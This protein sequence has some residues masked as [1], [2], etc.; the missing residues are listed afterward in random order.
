MD[1]NVQRVELQISKSGSS[2]QEESDYQKHNRDPKMWTKSRR[3]DI[4]LEELFE[5]AYKVATKNSYSY[6][7]N[8]TA[9]TRYITF[10]GNCV[11]VSGQAGSGKTTL[12]KQLVEKILEE[13]H[14]KVDFLFYVSLKNV[15]F[16]E[17]IGVLQ[18]LLTNLHSSWEH[19]VAT[20]K[21]LLQ[22][23]VETNKV[24]III[25]G[26]DEANMNL[27]GSCPTASIYDVTTPETILKNLLDG[28]IMPNAKKLITSRPRQLLE[29][30]E[31]YRPD[32][33]VNILGLNLD[34]QK[35][36]CRDICGSNSDR[37]YEYLVKHPELSAQCFV[38]VICI[39]TIYSLHQQQSNPDNSVAF[40]SV[41]NIILYILENFARLRVLRSKTF[42]LDKLSK[43]AWEGLRFKKYVFSDDDL[44]Q[45]KLKKENLDTVLTTGTNRSTKFRITHFGKITY[46]S[47]LIL[48][49][50]FS[51][52]YLILFAS[53]QEF[54]ET[55]SLESDQ[56]NLEVVKKFLFGLCNPTTYDR[57]RALHN[58]SD[59]NKT[60]LDL[61]QKNKFLKTFSSNVVK[62]PFLKRIRSKLPFSTIPSVDFSTYLSV[63]VWIYES[64][65]YDLTE[66]VAKLTSKHLLISGNIFPHEVSSLCYVLQARLQPLIIKFEQPK[67][68]GDS[69]ERFLEKLCD[70]QNYI[71]V[72]TNRLVIKLFHFCL[73]L[74]LSKFFIPNI[75]TV[76]CKQ[77]YGMESFSVL[78]TFPCQLFC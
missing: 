45:L 16:G 73:T 67:F 10:H 72:S 8:E 64:Q 23:L 55:L 13:T 25:D 28:H 47:H 21:A 19:D 4:V 49:E 34:A 77:G 52:A 65:Q 75:I 40:A 61:E 78:C 33:I 57:L 30:R 14:F 56:A 60:I 32:F 46:F 38:P 69:C 35:Q 29:L 18:F 6:T 36:I 5:E 44:Q 2:A 63:C 71:T 20:D 12:T 9:R 59:K 31:N 48:Q 76:L 22:E 15:K 37:V 74:E 43:L 42:E 54:K 62:G 26:L 17:K 11:A 7:N 24:M 3:G 27:E 50:F 58:S 41:T 51:A 68:V 70:M 39:F 1:Q 53:L 66:E